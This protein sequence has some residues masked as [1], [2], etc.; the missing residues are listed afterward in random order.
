MKKY[1]F[2]SLAAVAILSSCSQD[3]TM[4]VFTSADQI[5]FQA[6]TESASR[7]ITSFCA[8]NQPDEI[9]V[10]ART[11][12]A[13]PTFFIQNQKIVATGNGN[14]T[15]AVGTQYW[16]QQALDFIAF[17]GDMETPTFNGSISAPAF[18]NYRIA[19]NSANQL[20]LVYAVTPNRTKAQG[21]V[22]LNFRHA[23]SQAVFRARV[24]NK[25]TRVEIHNIAIGGIAGQG[26]FN[27]PADNTQTTFTGSHNDTSNSTSAQGPASGRGSWTS[28]SATGE[29]TTT[30]IEKSLTNASSYTTLTS[31]PE[32]H[33][34]NGDWSSVL[35]LIP[36][37]Q[38]QWDPAQGA[39]PAA[40]GGY[41][42]VNCTIYNQ[43]K[44]G[45]TTT[46]TI[47]HDGDLYIPMEIDWEQG[48]R[49]LYSLDF[50]AGDNAYTGSDAPTQALTKVS[51]NV[52][53]DDFVPVEQP[54]GQ[55]T[56]PGL[57]LMVDGTKISPELDFINGTI[58]L[59][60]T[61][62]APYDGQVLD[63][64]A[65]SPDSREVEYPAGAQLDFDGTNLTL[66]AVR[67]IE[68]TYCFSST[69]LT[70]NRVVSYPIIN[71]SASV[72]FPTYAE[73]QLP[74]PADDGK[75]DWT[76]LYWQM[77][78]GSTITATQ[79]NFGV[80]YKMTSSITVSA[81]WKSTRR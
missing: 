65:T 68:I 13:T 72:T 48:V 73:S 79:Y 66:Y 22:P 1:I 9:S 74:E 25:Y 57:S 24:S 32:G 56:V 14:Y 19:A 58:T 28:L 5:T 78:D 15:F 46:E 4:D 62:P 35:C 30:A 64:W 45:S 59:P 17:A 27:L 81:A 44:Q 77:M 53:V 20:D 54:A 63:G 2:A 16:P 29:F 47:A 55:E 75:Y 50:G 23:L 52:S 41:L 12:E 69:A 42:K 31:S 26:T 37:N 7:A 43:A 49:Y 40:N 51:V 33:R 39:A 18:E 80:S 10:Y 70:T 71:G 8:N 61:L 60:A 76:P 11:V 3:E 38:P 36:Q 6:T 67:H 34:A 21:T